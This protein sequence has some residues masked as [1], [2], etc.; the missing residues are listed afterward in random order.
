MAES[1]QDFTDVQ[2]VLRDMQSATIP[3]IEADI[4]ALGVWQDYTPVMQFASIGNGSVSG[5]YIQ[6]SK[7]VIAYGSFL[8]GSTSTV[9]AGFSM[10][11]P[12]AP[13]DTIGTY[14]PMGIAVYNDASG[15]QYP[16]IIWQTSTTRFRFIHD[17]SPAATASDTVPFT[18]TTSD[19][20]TWHL[21]YEAA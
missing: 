10:D 17:V 21:T 15:S 12:V 19:V 2:R 16:G 6:I 8:L 7:L 1:V 5:R 20:A 4:A 11:P 9:S 13:V 3:G 14:A 18:W